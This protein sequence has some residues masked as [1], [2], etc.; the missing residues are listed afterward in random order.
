MVEHSGPVDVRSK[1]DLMELHRPPSIQDLTMKDWNPV[2]AQIP[3]VDSV[4]L[5]HILTGL[6]SLLL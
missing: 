5:D 4:K 3:F 1:E 2:K 6:T